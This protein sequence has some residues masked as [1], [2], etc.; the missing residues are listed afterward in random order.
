MALVS[1][2]GL[3][4]SWL[5]FHSGLLES[6]DFLLFRQED[7]QV[8]LKLFESQVLLLGRLCPHYLQDRK[9]TNTDPSNVTSLQTL[10]V[11]YDS[12]VISRCHLLNLWGSFL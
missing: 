10:L 12:Q 4:H 1:S 9:D 7:F 2:W 11:M 5:S 8:T 6:T 3:W